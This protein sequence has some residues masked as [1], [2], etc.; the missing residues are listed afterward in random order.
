MEITTHTHSV[1][2]PPSL[3]QRCK[4]KK[5]SLMN[6]LSVIII[7]YCFLLDFIGKVLKFDLF[8]FELKRIC[9]Y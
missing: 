8:T 3:G 2:F 5:V 6:I 9:L 4:T 1:T 7:P